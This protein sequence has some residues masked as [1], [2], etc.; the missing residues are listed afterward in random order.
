MA[1]NVRSAPIQPEVPKVLD[2]EQINVYVPF[3][4]EFYAGIAYYDTKHFEFKLPGQVSLDPLIT[5]TLNYVRRTLDST[6]DNSALYGNKDGYGNSLLHTGEQTVIGAINEHHK[7]IGKG[8]SDADPAYGVERPN[9]NYVNPEGKESGLIALANSTHRWVTYFIT[10]VYP[11]HLREFANHVDDFEKYKDEAGARFSRIESDI[12]VINGTLQVHNTRITY[13]E[14]K[15]GNDDL[16]T[17]AQTL[18]G[19]INEVDDK[20]KAN[21]RNIVGLTAQIHGIGKTYVVQTFPDFIKFIEAKLKVINYEDRDGDGVAEAYEIGI[22]DLKTGDNVLIAETYVPDFWFEK[23][24]S[25]ANACEYTYTDENGVETTYDLI[26]KDGDV[27]YGLLYQLEARY[28][29]GDVLPLVSAEDE[30]K[31]LRVI[32]GDWNV[33]KVLNAEEAKF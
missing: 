6:T 20:T 5:E 29:I 1:I 31:F 9:Q 4:T 27:I 19:G 23:T 7:V 8:I 25:I 11:A 13:I 15:I 10:D 17:D 32:N 30:G 14:N 24:T 2:N 16:Q 26:G 28:I 18:I 21:A 33:A 22:A 3:A 12:T